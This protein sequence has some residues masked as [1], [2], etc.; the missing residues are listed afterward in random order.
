MNLSLVIGLEVKTGGGVGPDGN[1]QCFTRQVPQGRPLQ[2]SQADE[3]LT[4]QLK[5]EGLL[6][7]AKTHPNLEVQCPHMFPF[8]FSGSCSFFIN[9]FLLQQTACK[10]GNSI[11]VVI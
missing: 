8:H 3:G 10:V 4:S 5:V 6:L 9:A 2:T 7:L 1:Q 11:S